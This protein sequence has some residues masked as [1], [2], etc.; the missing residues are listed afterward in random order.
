MIVGH[1]EYGAHQAVLTKHCAYRAVLLEH[2]AHQAVLT[3][4]GAYRAVLPS[5][6]LIE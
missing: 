1:M 6:V 2:G 5:I 3:K 4:H